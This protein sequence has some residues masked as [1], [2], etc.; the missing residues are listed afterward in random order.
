[1]FFR[2]NTRTEGF[3][4]GGGA[5]GV[6]DL[7]IKYLVLWNVRALESE[8]LCTYR[9]TM[10]L[11]KWIIIG[12]I[13]PEDP[14]AAVTVRSETLLREFEEEKKNQ[15]HLKYYYILEISSGRDRRTR[16]IA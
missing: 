4:F 12:T 6:I 15:A 16:S 7:Q 13:R 8:S 2:K 10:C 14:T 1:M 11:R 9:V 5:H 3:F